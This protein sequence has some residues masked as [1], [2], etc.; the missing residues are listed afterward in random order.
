MKA[1]RNYYGMLGL[2]IGSLFTMLLTPSAMAGFFSENFEEYT[3]P[4]NVVDIGNGWYASSTNVVVTSALFTNNAPNQVAQMSPGEVVSNQVSTNATRI[5]TEA[6]LKGTNFMT[7]DSV[8]PANTAAVFMV[9]LSTN[10]YLFLCNPTSLAWE[11]CSTDAAGVA[12][13]DTVATGTWARVSVF[14]NYANHQV[15]IFLNDRLIRKELPFIN[16]NCNSYTTLRFGGA[17]AGNVSIDNVFVSNSTPPGLVSDSDHDGRPDAEEFTLF[18]SLTNWNGSVITA[19]VSNN[20]GGAVAPTNSGLVRW[21]GQTNFIFTAAPAYCVDR[22]WTNG[23]LEQNYSNLSLKTASFNWTNITADGSL[24]VGFF[25]SGIRYIPGDYSTLTAALAA[26]QAGDQLVISNGN[27]N[28]AVVINSNLSFSGSTLTGLTAI[29]IQTGVTVTVSGFTN[30]SVSGV[31]QVDSNGTLVI[32]N[33]VVNMAGLVIQDGALIHGYNSTATVNGVLYTGTFTIDQNW[34]VVIQA[35]PFNF[36]ETF[37]NYATGSRLDG[38]KA[39]GWNASD[40]AAMVEPNPDSVGNLSAKAALV[41]VG[42]TIS[43]LMDGVHASL[44]NV[45][46]DVMIRGDAQMEYT[47]VID[48]NGTAPVMVFVNTNS[49]LVVLTPGGWVVCS[50]DAWGGPAPTITNGEWAGVSWF[51]DYGKQTVAYFVKG[52]LVRQEM[53][54]AKPATR[55]HGLKLEANATTTWLDNVNLWTNVPTGLLTGPASD[56]NNDGMADALEIQ[57]FG[58]T[59][60]YPAGSVFKI[61]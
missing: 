60:S 19:S 13:V 21:Q 34:N 3:V 25:Y 49:Y 8:P 33:G 24:A 16:T 7:P 57:L 54:F 10:G 47:D 4:T 53:P 56:V 18:G 55:Y 37:E 5:W 27:Y 41:P 52:H 29:T 43:N 61:R 40:A 44:T 22:V 1:Q 14:Q 50:N 6:W 35:H 45:W 51:M 17:S 38:L 15:A 23:G 28:E 59:Y 11:V 32:T 46:T 42:V 12:I 9:G 48:T 36:S 30:L 26:A 2:L 58:N 20:I 31:V 39:N